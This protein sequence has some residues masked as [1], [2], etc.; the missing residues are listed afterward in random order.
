MCATVAIGTQIETRIDRT[1]VLEIEPK[2]LPNVRHRGHRFPNR[3][4]TRSRIVPQCAPPSP[5]VPKSLPDVRHRGHRNSD[6]NQNRSDDRAGNGTEIACQCAPPWPSISKPKSE[7]NGESCRNSIPN[8][9]PMC[10][11]IVIGKNHSHI[12]FFD[13]IGSTGVSKRTL[14]SGFRRTRCTRIDQE[15]TRNQQKSLQNLFFRPSWVA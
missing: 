12:D 6:R 10:A 2:S 1:T 15:S 7:S 9:R 5:S 14:R 4:E 13:Q 3:V 11:T 8:R